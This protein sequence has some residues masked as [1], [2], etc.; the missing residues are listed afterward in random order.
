MKIDRNQTIY[1]FLVGFSQGTW[2]G[3]LQMDLV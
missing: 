2:D 3:H 1:K